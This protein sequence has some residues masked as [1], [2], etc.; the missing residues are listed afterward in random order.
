MGVL[1][2]MLE[3]AL[4][5]SAEADAVLNFGYDW[6]PLWITPWVPAPLFHLISMGAVSMVMKRAIESVS[7]WNQGRL[8]FHTLR[9]ASD[10]DL[11]QPARVVGNGFDLS[12]YSFREESGGPLGWAGRIAPKKGWRMQL[13]PRQR[14]V[15]DCWSGDCLK[16]LLMPKL[17]FGPSR[18]DRMAGVL[19]HI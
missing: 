9:Q 19:V 14:S 11:L 3:E 10:F 6:L 15:I 16:M 7:R 1:P 18:H 13:R 5:L 2:A 8:A 12:Q 17:K 4:R